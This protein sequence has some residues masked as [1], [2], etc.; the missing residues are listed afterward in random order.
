MNNSLSGAVVTAA[1]HAIGIEVA[2][3]FRKLDYRI[4]AKAC[5][6]EPWDDLNT[7]TVAGDIVCPGT[8]HRM[9]TEGVA[10]LGR[11]HTLARDDDGLRARR[12]R[13]RANNAGI[14][15]AEP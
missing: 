1:S 2:K 4:V 5:T 13:A 3:A 10:C 11:I 9:T 14:F 12:A 8:V 6:V 7:V 15:F